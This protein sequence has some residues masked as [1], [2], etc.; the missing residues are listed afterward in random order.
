MEK[1]LKKLFDYQ[2]FEKNERLEK[3]IRETESR[4]AKELSDDDLS[5]VN[6]AGETG[7]NIGGLTGDFTG[8][9][10]IPGE[11]QVGGLSGSLSGENNSGSVSGYNTG[12]LTGSFSD[13]VGGLIG[14][15]GVGGGGVGGKDPAM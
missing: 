1:K 3:L 7:V 12:G 15:G 9:Y 5:L 10:T 14:T 13:E 6:A 4:Y 2:R 11:T 8:N